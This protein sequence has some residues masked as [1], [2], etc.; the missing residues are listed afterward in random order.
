M[1]DLIEAKESIKKMTRMNSIRFQEK[2][3][4]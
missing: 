2:K 4:G 1:S 3:K